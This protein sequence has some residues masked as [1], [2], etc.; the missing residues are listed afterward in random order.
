M[1][2][3]DFFGSALPVRNINMEE[4]APLR[5]DANNEAMIKDV[6]SRPIGVCGE[7]N[8]PATVTEIKVGLNRLA[9]R[10]F[11]KIWNESAN[12]IRIGPNPAMTFSGAARGGLLGPGDVACIKITD[13]VPYYMIAAGASNSVTILEN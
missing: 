3:V 6:I 5:N 1:S 12:I 4:T 11:V 10:N 2:D 9:G 8:C 13:Q 7:V